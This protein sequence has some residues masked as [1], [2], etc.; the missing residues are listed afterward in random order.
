MQEEAWLDW[1]T[2]TPE[3][4]KMMM[5]TEL[6]LTDDTVGAGMCL[7]NPAVNE[8]GVMLVL[9]N[10]QLAFAKGRSP[11]EI[12]K[13]ERATYIALEHN[14]C[15]VHRV[16]HPCVHLAKAITSV[17]YLINSNCPRLTASGYDTS[18]IYPFSLGTRASV[19]YV[20]LL[21]LDVHV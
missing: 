8:K 16:G 2:Y 6:T 11:T 17:G 4:S 9:G 19:D 14:M 20:F 21:V 18:R 13:S 10:N 7:K 3:T 5:T 15:H 12:G 1:R